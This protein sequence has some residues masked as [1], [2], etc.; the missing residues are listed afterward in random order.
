MMFTAVLVACGLPGASAQTPTTPDPLVQ[1]I[2]ALDHVL[3]ESGF[4]ACDLEPVHEI[5]ADDLEFF[6]DL[7]GYNT[8]RESFMAAL[9]NN[10]CA[11][12]GEL[13]PTR[14][15]VEGSQT[16]YPLHAGGQLYGAIQEGVHTFHLGHG[17]NAPLT[18]T[19]RFVHVWLVSPGADDW[20]LSEVLSFDH[21]P[22]PPPATAEHD[23]H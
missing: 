14:R 12:T 17:P 2:K 20:R 13:K 9:R 21:R 6:H 7:G 3:F 23:P 4:N 16:I 19:A 5:I 1:R 8:G 18:S 15:L 11:P 10:I 22:P